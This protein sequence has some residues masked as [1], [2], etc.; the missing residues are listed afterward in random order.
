MMLEL[1]VLV[2]VLIAAASFCVA[3]D[4]YQ[5]RTEHVCDLSGLLL[6]PLTST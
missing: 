4:Y 1:V 6:E 3:Y 5:A 2:H